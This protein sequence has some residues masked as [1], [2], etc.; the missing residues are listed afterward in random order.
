MP[1]TPPKLYPPPMHRPVRKQPRTLLLSDSA[2]TP[3]AS[4][5]GCTALGLSFAASLAQPSSNERSR[6]TYLNS[7]YIKGLELQRTMWRARLVGA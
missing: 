2:S 4:G 7:R 1:T 3:V 5:S 6:V